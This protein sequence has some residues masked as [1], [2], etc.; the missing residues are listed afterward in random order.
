MLAR[1]SKRYAVMSSRIRRKLSQANTA[2]ATVASKATPSHQRWVPVVVASATIG[3]ILGRQSFPD[4]E[5]KDPLHLPNGLPRTCCAK[6][7]MTDQQKEVFEKVKRI[8][9][10]SNILDGRDETTETSPFLKGARLGQGSA[11]CI[12]RPKKL[13]EL[14]EV[15]R[16]VVEGGCAILIQGQN[17][18]LVSFFVLL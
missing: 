5:G 18:G 4:T 11:L 3:F 1:A 6:T 15:V 13:R 16:V 2:K 10:A 7:E 12:V 8:V 14:L 9:G 17:T